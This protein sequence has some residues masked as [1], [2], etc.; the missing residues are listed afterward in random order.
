MRLL[1][2][3]PLTNAIP[4]PLSLFVTVEMAPRT[5][6][7]QQ[8]V[9]LPETNPSFAGA[10]FY[11][12]RKTWSHHQWHVC[13]GS[14]GRAARHRGQGKLQ[15]VLPVS[16]L[17]CDTATWATVLCSTGSPLVPSLCCPSKLSEQCSAWQH[18]A[19]VILALPPVPRE[20][21]EGM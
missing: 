17:L 2:Y 21:K 13:L 8:D 16:A 15:P 10:A 18:L 7:N 3:L 4:P 20:A 19:A 11:R 9:L 14:N 12:N 1:L 6:H 5:S